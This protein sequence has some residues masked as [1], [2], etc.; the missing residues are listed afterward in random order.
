VKI[1]FIKLDGNAENLNIADWYVDTT[2]RIF[3]KHKTLGKVMLDFDATKKDAVK[4]QNI[5]HI[6]KCE[7][8]V[9]LTH[10]NKT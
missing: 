4:L 7:L 2:Y 5:I 6:N 8:S 3:K 9:C 1:L 10:Y